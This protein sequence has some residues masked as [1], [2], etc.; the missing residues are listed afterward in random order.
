VVGERILGRFRIEARLGSGGFGTVYRAW[1]QRL[2]RAVAVKAIDGQGTTTP[3]R[4]TRE[5]QAAARLSHPGIATLYEL[6]DDGERVYLVSELVEGETLRALAIRGLLTDAVI[7]EAGACGASALAH[8]HR[9]GVVHRDI[10]PQNILV[11]S[12]G[13]GAKLVDFGIARI[14]G[15]RTLTASGAVL[16][17]LAYMAPEQA[18]GLRPGPAADVYSLALTLYECWANGHP[19]LRAGPAATARAI[20]QPVPSLAASRPDLPA[21]VVET[22]DRCLEGDPELRPLA[23]ELEAELDAAVPGLD[24][25]PLPPLSVPEPSEERADPLR[26]LPEMLASLGALAASTLAGT[27]IA[28]SGG[29]L[30][31]LPVAVA[32]FLLALRRPRAALLFAAAATAGWLAT[33]G[34]W[35]GAALVAAVLCA[36]LL[37]LPPRSSAAF[38]LPAAAPLLGIAGLAGAYPALAGLVRGANGRAILGAVGYLWLAAAE[39][40]GERD[41]LLGSGA[42]APSE[43]R[44]SVGEAVTGVL[45]PLAEPSV[46]AGCLLW[47]AAALLLPALVRGSVALLDLLGAIV[48]AAALVAGHRLIGGF[49]GEPPDGL[50]L[51]VLLAAMLAVAAARALR[52][53]AAVRTA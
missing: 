32:V 20:G 31:A 25:G 52:R 2:Q 3:R 23:S 33:G 39:L 13:A 30:V 43:W 42:A 40:L 6:A 34:G 15:E 19:L 5:A 22:I 37:L 53:S 46:L 8:A 10:K 48:W 4:V 51:A 35:P 41:L 24:D 27:A 18:E 49:A 38:S 29:S 21:E 9:H 7:A 44:S 12:G 16:G 47:A 36:P 11:P 50:L 26:P 28:W 45:M 1:D 14:A 17:T